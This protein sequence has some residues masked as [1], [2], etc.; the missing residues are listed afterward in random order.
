MKYVFHLGVHQT[1]IP[2]VQRTLDD[3]IDALRDAGVFYV[4]HEAPVFLTRQ[5]R[6][7]RRVC[8]PTTETP[9]PDALLNINRGMAKQARRA[10]AQVVLL[11]ADHGLGPA[12]HE[13]LDW[14]E[15]PPEFYP[16]APTCV[17]YLIAGLPPRRTQIMLS[18]RNPETYLTSLY[19]QAI[20]DGLTNMTID[21]FCRAVALDSIK[22]EALQ[23]RL[24]TLNPNVGM[25]MRPYERI[26]LGSETFMRTFLRDAGIEP[27]TITVTGAPKD[28]TLDA[29]Q[30]EALRHISMGSPS[31]RP[32]LVDQLREKILSHSANPMD[33]LS[34]PSWVAE[35][36]R[37]QEHDGTVP[38]ARTAA[39]VM[40]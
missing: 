27:G 10:G 39:N 7:L 34:L 17:D 13:T 23:T 24:S 31:Q 12:M 22:F 33:R 15:Y 28:D 6:V 1:S 8:H 11:V 40:A 32:E 14:S 16:I 5:R 3:N 38:V 26:R 30:V 21:A 9:E 19:S 36:L 20:R 35:R 2:Y 29:A 25:S 18:S 4:N 37:A